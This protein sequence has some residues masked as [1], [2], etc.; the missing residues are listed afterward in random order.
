MAEHEDEDMDIGQSF[1]T[2]DSMTDQPLRRKL[3]K[4]VLA[5]QMREQIKEKTQDDLGADRNSPKKDKEKK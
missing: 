2:T 4:S 5:R 3:H 1:R